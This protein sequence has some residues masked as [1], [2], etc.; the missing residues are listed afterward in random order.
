MDL[1]KIIIFYLALCSCHNLHSKT[2]EL[3]YTSEDLEILKKQNNHLEFLNHALD[4]RP[5]K[6][7][8]KWEE[9][10][11]E[12]ATGFIAS[13]LSK[14]QISKHHFQF[15]ENLLSWPSLKNDEFFL[16]KR[17]QFGYKFI[18]KCFKEKEKPQICQKLL[19]QF[20]YNHKDPELGIKL[21][22]IIQKQNL[23]IDSW[24]F[25]DKA[26]KSPFS[27]FF[28]KD[29]NLKTAL[30]KKAIELLNKNTIE[31]KK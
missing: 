27:N 30:F 11:Q 24:Q 6:R 22:H 16:I 18:D 21:G 12:M 14:K 9:M 4:I 29:Q 7:N 13:T 10:V 26:T 28:C 15:I 25:Y 1:F 8:K 5:S 3:L 31:E 19:L 20:W 2:K 17:N 23:S